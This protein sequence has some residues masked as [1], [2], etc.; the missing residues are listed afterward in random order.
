MQRTIEYGSQKRRPVITIDVFSGEIEQWACVATR[1]K[2]LAQDGKTFKSAA[3]KF[4]RKHA[5]YFK[6]RDIRLVIHN[7][8][9]ERIK[10]NYIT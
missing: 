7:R 10:V 2:W 6:D 5:Q 4:I 1:P 8:R 9:P 3:K